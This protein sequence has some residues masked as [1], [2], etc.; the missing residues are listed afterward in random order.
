M[1]F[2]YIC[3]LSQ[4]GHGEPNRNCSI[5]DRLVCR[6]VAVVVG[7]GKETRQTRWRQTVDI[8][9]GS[10]IIDMKCGRNALTTDWG[11]LWVKSH[12]TDIRFV[13]HAEWW[14]ERA[15]IIFQKGTF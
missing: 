15:R 1:I 6:F 3:C 11:L 9:S 13:K 7:C 4:F 8:R 2:Y 5:V 14:T 10:A 12:H